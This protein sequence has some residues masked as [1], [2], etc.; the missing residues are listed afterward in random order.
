M[1][2]WLQDGKILCDRN[3]CPIDCATCPCQGATCA[4]CKDCPQP[5]G[6]LTL[7]SPHDD[8]I[9]NP[10][11]LPQL[12]PCYFQAQFNLAGLTVSI[13]CDNGCFTI[14]A[15]GYT[16]PGAYIA[17]ELSGVCGSACP[18]A[19][20]YELIALPGYDDIGTVTFTLA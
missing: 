8:L 19:G 14:H 6:T 16:I 13:G 3:G 12:L 11:N 17:Y 2:Y 1:A 7:P 5:V 4:D 20:D 15:Q 9:V 18:P 10:Q